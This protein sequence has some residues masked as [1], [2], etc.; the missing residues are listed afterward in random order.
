M[1]RSF[2]KKEPVLVISG[3][4]AFLS[5]F[6]V[7]PS[8]AYLSYIDFRTLGLLFCLMAAVAGLSGAGVFDAMARVLS[9]KAGTVRRLS[10]LLVLAAFGLSMFITNDVALITFVPL[11]ILMLREA[12]QRAL[13]ITVVMETIGANLGSALTPFRQ[14]PE[15]L[16]LFPVR[17]GHRGIFIRHRAPL[18]HRAFA[19]C[20]RSAGFPASGAKYCPKGRGSR[21]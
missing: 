9:Q 12:G 5:V 3:T 17:H 14:P 7:P 1:V 16:P 15:P 4:L 8:A 11:T 6:F 18:P 21:L 19:D 20:R 10:L 2:L 13:I